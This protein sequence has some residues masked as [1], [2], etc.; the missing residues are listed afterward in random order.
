MRR[1]DKPGLRDKPSRFYRKGGFFAF[2][3]RLNRLDET[4]AH[5]L[6]MKKT[7]TGMDSCP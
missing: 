1:D 7:R 3:P 4:L 6:Q 2:R 5:V